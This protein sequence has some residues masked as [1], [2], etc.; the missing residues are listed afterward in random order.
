[1]P[2][3]GF[4]ISLRLFVRYLP[5]VTTRRRGKKGR[6]KRE[7]EGREKIEGEGKGE[8][9]RKEVGYRLNSTI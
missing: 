5:L 1:V 2:F 9:R 8:D 4:L 3:S 6:R 7:G